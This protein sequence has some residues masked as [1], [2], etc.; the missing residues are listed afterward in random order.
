MLPLVLVISLSTALGPLGGACTAR[1]C[2]AEIKALTNP[3]ARHYLTCI[4]GGIGAESDNLKSTASSR[5][6]DLGKAVLVLYRDVRRCLAPESRYLGS[7]F[8][9]LL[10]KSDKRFLQVPFPG[11]P[12]QSP[13]EEIREPELPNS[14]TASTP[15]HSPPRNH[16]ISKDSGA[17]K[18]TLIARVWRRCPSPR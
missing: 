13:V 8:L 9:Y 17:T 10:T 1:R 11:S 3:V 15:G 6:A 5:V 2:V 18:T 16:S 7:T 14:R 4:I 12:S